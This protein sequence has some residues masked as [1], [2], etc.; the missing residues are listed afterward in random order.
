MPRQSAPPLTAARGVRALALVA[1]SLLAVACRTQAP[2][3]S[4]TAT[5]AVTALPTG[6]VPGVTVGGATPAT[7]LSSAAG[8]ATARIAALLPEPE[9][10][11]GREG[12]AP[13][14]WILPQDVA[15]DAQGNLYVSDATG[16][17]K[18]GPDGTFLARLGAD[19][20]K[21]A[22]GGIA[23]APSGKLYVTGFESVVHVFDTTSGAATTIGTPGDGPGGL[24]Q[25][26]DV[27]LDTDGNVYVADAGNHRVEKFA[28]DGTHLLTVGG[29]GQSSG[30]FTSP[31]SVAVD[32]EGRLYVAEGDDYLVQRFAPDGTYLDTFGHAYADENAWRVG[33]IAIDEQGNV[34]VTQA[35]AGRVQCF[36]A[37][38]LDLRWELGSVGTAPDQFTS[39][40][41]VTVTGGRMYVADQQNHRIAVYR[42]QP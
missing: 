23:L 30:Q 14:E 28:P 15:V 33:G 18:V 3:P 4:P 7:A 36:D 40:I 38:K 9:T 41:G 26:V 35:L 10:T 6:G 37:A 17:Q 31:R 20:L 8:T 21:T 12:T 42:L 39:P 19:V 2:P 11:L 29:S 24:R 27:A 16:V 13:G 1:L 34:Y 22:M 32:G 25:P 5:D